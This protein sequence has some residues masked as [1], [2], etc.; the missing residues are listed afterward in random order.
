MT[1]INF[2]IQSNN[3]FLVTEENSSDAQS[4]HDSVTISL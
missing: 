3:N 4:I 1:K 2:E